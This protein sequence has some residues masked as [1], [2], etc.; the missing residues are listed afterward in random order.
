MTKIV[1]LLNTQQ[2]T[3][4]QVK[5]QTAVISYGFHKLTLSLCLFSLSNQHFTKS[6]LTLNPSQLL[7]DTVG[8]VRDAAAG[9][10]GTAMKVVGEKFMSEYINDLD[11]IKKQKVNQLAL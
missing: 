3:V 7:D 10:L 1:R 6:T 9:A 4:K 8:S 2:S 11:S 5:V